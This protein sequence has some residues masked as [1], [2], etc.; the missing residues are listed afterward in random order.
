MVDTS[1]LAEII[2]GIFRLP[3]RLVVGVIDG[4]NTRWSQVDRQRRMGFRAGVMALLGLISLAWWNE[5]YVP[6]TSK[7][8]LARL[9]EGHCWVTYDPTAL[10]PRRGTEP[11]TPSIRR[12]L[13]R[14]RAAGFTGVVTFSSRGGF[15][16]I[17][18]IAKSENLAVIMGVWSPADVGE[19]RRAIAQQE[20]ADAYCVGHD[21]LDKRDGYAL[22]DLEKAILLLKRRT[23]RPVTTS[24]EVRFYM[25]PAL[26]RLGDWLFPDIHISLL[27]A[28]SQSLRQASGRGLGPIVDLTRRISAVAAETERPL[29]LKMVTFPWNGFEGASLENQRDNFDRFLEALRS[30]EQGI[31]A[32]PAVVIHSAFD[33]SWKNGYPFYD[34]DPYTG[35]L[36]TD[37]SSRPAT[38]VI[39]ARC[40]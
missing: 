37:G 12:D 34:W 26:S 31:A 21:G 2:A 10:D 16:Q 32:R 24:E 27:N 29:M 13:R 30:P 19:L 20:F 18:R 9:L 39:V 23:M 25:N 6:S 14:I 28:S 36:D 5:V 35:V 11:T 22:E 15:A 4:F 33:L 38:Q 17:P 7:R 8:E 40:Q 1:G 3:L